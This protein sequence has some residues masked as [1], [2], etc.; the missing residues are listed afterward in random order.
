MKRKSVLL[1]VFAGWLAIGLHGKLL[2]APAA[3]SPLRGSSGAHIQLAILLDTSGSMDGLLDQAKSRLWKIVNELAT[4]RKNGRGPH[5]RD[6][7]CGTGRI[8]I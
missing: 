2:P 4:A 6:L 3:P 5:H 8:L 1:F 7:R